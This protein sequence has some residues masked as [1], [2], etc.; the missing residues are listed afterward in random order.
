MARGDGPEP[1]A[2]LARHRK[3]TG[4]Q[5]G[6]SMLEVIPGAARTEPGAT[7]GTS[8][9]L[10]SPWSGDRSYVVAVPRIDKVERHQVTIHNRRIP[11]SEAYRQGLAA[12]LNNK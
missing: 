4:Y 11:V 12:A 2:P 5:I 8:P 9:P 1:A 7:A 6:S 3:L 10:R